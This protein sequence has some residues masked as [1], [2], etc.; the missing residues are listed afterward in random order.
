MVP[1]LGLHQAPV[2]VVEEKEPLQLRPRQHLGQPTVGRSLLIGQKLN[3]QLTGLSDLHPP[4]AAEPQRSFSKTIKAVNQQIRASEALAPVSTVPMFPK[5]LAVSAG[6][7][8]RG[9]ES[10]RWVNTGS[11]V[12]GRQRIVV[13]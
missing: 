4:T 9:R 11:R 10:A 13:G 7:G 5:P 3:W 6:A 8:W 2:D 1:A 12:Q